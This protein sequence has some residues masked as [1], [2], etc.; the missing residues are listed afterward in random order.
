MGTKENQKGSGR[1]IIFKKWTYST[2]INGIWIVECA[3]LHVINNNKVLMRTE[4][5]VAYLSS[6]MFYVIEN[7]CLP[8]PQ[9][10][11]KVDIL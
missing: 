7:S 11:Q 9:I 5:D 10:G 3:I 1:R 4:W 6:E 2:C 8:L